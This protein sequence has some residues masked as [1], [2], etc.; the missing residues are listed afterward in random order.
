MRSSCWCSAL[1]NRKEAK[2]KHM[3]GGPKRMQE[4][5]QCVQN[6]VAC[7][8]E[9]D[10]F[11]SDPATPTLRTLQSAMPASYELIVDFNSAHAAGE[12]KLT[13]FL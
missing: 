8:H 11:P 4:N 5:E 1:A 13:S 10:S 6:L 12:E 3:E 9:F 7:M 2:R